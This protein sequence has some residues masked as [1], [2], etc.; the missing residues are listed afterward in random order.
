MKALVL[1]AGKGK[2]LHS[3]MHN[4]PKVLR[5]VNGK[6]LISYVL[7]NISFIPDEDIIII[8]GYK[9]EMVMQYLNGRYCF[10]FQDEQ[11]GTGHAV[12]MAED[13][14]K[15]YDDDV[16]VLYGDMPL[17]RDK[18]LRIFIEHHNKEKACCSVMTAVC[19]TPPAYGRIIRDNDG[20]LLDIVEEKDCSSEEKKIKE[21]NVG[22]YIFKSRILFAS[23]KKLKNINSQKEYYLTDIPR[24]ILSQGIYVS[25]YTLSDNEE[26]L[27]VNTP[28]ELYACESILKRR[29][30][31]D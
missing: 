3:E 30:N 6:P 9:K 7:D 13:L 22:V 1:A 31:H 11:L 15:D 24:I 19:D 23:L 25:T 8:A 16:L 29:E 4:L 28:E 21:V 12:M 26:M 27:G 2:R 18:S 17:L 10:A 14:L 5:S 20:R